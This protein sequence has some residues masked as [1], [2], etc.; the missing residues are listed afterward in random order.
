MQGREGQEV[1]LNLPFSNFCP[2]PSVPASLQLPPPSFPLLFGGG[3]RA[4]PAGP[5][6]D[7]PSPRPGGRAGRGAVALPAPAGRAAWLAG[8][9]L[10]TWRARALSAELERSCGG[11]RLEP[12]SAGVQSAAEQE[13][14]E[15]RSWAGGCG[16]LSTPAPHL[17]APGSL[18]AGWGRGARCPGRF[19]PGRRARSQMRKGGSRT[20]CIWMSWHGV[21]EKKKKKQTKVFWSVEI[22]I[23]GWLEKAF[24]SF[25]K[26]QMC[27]GFEVPKEVE[28]IAF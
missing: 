27:A 17:P 22:L 5:P 12:A 20:D 9:G 23:L 6:P 15:E 18:D 3:E 24:S 11:F 8:T 14:R 25:I 21:Y 28:I 16:S 13:E 2:P 10:G 1:D 4:L 19:H 26:D 7:P